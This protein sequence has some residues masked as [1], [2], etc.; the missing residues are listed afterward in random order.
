MSVK[1][2]F[3]ALAACLA[4]SLPLSAGDAHSGIKISD[5]YAR[6]ATPSSKSGA[7][8]MMVMNHGAHTDRLIAVQSSAAKRSELHTHKEDANGV[9]KMIH[10]EDGFEVP[11]GGMLMLKR[12]GEHVMLMGLTDPLEQGGTVTLELTFEKAGVITVDVPVD[13]TR[14]P[15]AH[16]HSGG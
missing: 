14:K 16:S 2:L 7:A 3:A 6:A 11:A 12:G 10:V 8:F 9:M 1:P 5:A 15:G 4:L 13:L